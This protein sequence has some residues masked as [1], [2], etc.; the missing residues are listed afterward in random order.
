MAALVDQVLEHAAHFTDVARLG[1]VEAGIGKGSGGALSSGVGEFLVVI[2][3]RG[4]A[5]E[6]GEA[7][8]GELHGDHAQLRVDGVEAPVVGGGQARQALVGELRGQGAKMGVNDVEARQLAAEL[9]ELVADLLDLGLGGAQLVEIG[10]RRDVAEHRVELRLQRVEAVAERMQ[11]RLRA[12]TGKRLLD[13]HGDFGEALVEVVGVHG[14]AARRRLR[15]VGHDSGG[16]AARGAHIERLLRRRR[17]RRL[18]RTRSGGRD[19]RASR[20]IGARLAAVRTV[21]L[22]LV[23]LDE[24]L[25][26]SVIPGVDGLVGALGAAGRAQEDDLVARHAGHANVFL[27][28]VANGLDAR[29]GR[30]LLHRIVGDN[31]PAAEVGQ[32]L[33]EALHLR[34][35]AFQVRLELVRD[36]RSDGPRLLAQRRQ[37]ATH[38][39]Q[40][41]RLGGLVRSRGA[42]IGAGAIEFVVG[43]VRHL[44]P[45]A[46][47]DGPLGAVGSCGGCLP[48]R[49]AQYGSP[50]IP[51]V[52]ES[53]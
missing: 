16:G 21:H 38:L 11:R 48:G 28:D 39:V 14:A 19:A 7:L 13:A 30:A 36:L 22:R 2:A 51:R 35:D 43:L 29:L 44:N 23:E 5:D 10:A 42:G 27:G 52:R 4:A 20:G 50:L 3:G 12:H 33:A 18:L 32:P 46:L 26:G 41:I 17:G 9:T 25:G 37:P 24:R 40:H 53:R 8:V 31:G 49:D 47:V 1:A 45:L 15:R 6:P 34:L